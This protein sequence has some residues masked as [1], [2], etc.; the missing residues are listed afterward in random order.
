MAID[1]LAPIALGAPL[2]GEI[3]AWDLRALLGAGADPGGSPDLVFGPSYPNL[4]RMVARRRQETTAEH[5][6]PIVVQAEAPACNEARMVE[7]DRKLV[8]VEPGVGAVAGK[9]LDR[10]VEE[11]PQRSLCT[12]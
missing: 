6:I 1:V 2:N 8:G 3:R 4:D 12:V 10:G 5:G 11:A 9:P 7:E